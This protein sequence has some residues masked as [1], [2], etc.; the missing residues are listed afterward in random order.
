[1]QLHQ[2]TLNIIKNAI[3]AMPDGTGV[4]SVE[5]KNIMISREEADTFKELSPG[6][7]VRLQVKDTGIGIPKS[8]VDRIFEPFFTTK[9]F[10]EGT[11]LG[12]A[13]VHGIVS[14][15]KG[16]I[17]ISSETDRGTTVSV[18]VPG[19]SENPLEQIDRKQKARRGHGH[20]LFIDDDENIVSVC[21]TMLTLLGY[22]CMGV[23]GGEEALAVFVQDPDRF[24][25]VITDLKMPG[26]NGIY[27][28]RELLRIKPEIPIVLCTGD[29]DMVTPGQASSLGFQKIIMKPI[30]KS[31]LAGV[32]SEILTTSCSTEAV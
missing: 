17:V 20:I 2:V 23:S 3:Q 1:V 11:G 5:C 26:I 12:L 22:E 6:L 32:L 21:K 29:S 14:S 30:L 8:V 28:A 27:L 9:K 7:Y 31:D 16:E 13:I 25:A 4:L 10:G 15:L 19:T 24:D 18:Y